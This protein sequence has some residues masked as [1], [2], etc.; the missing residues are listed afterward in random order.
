MTGKRLPER[1]PGMFLF[2]LIYINRYATS[3]FEKN[4]RFRWKNPNFGTKSA[5][6][7]RK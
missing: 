2:L 5:K 4:I 1:A 7:D 3:G 6:L